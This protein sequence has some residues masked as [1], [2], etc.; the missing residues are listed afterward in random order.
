LV[1]AIDAP[2]EF[3]DDVWPD[4]A[5]EGEDDA[6]GCDVVVALVLSPSTAAVELGGVTAITLK[7]L[8]EAYVRSC[9]GTERVIDAEDPGFTRLVA[10]VLILRVVS[11]ESCGVDGIGQGKEVEHGRADRVKLAGGHDVTRIRDAGGGVLDRDQAI[12]SG[13]CLREIARAFERR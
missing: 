13:D 6:G 3:V 1:R 10:I 4:A 12:S 5:D 11:A 7:I 9:F 8:H 2:G